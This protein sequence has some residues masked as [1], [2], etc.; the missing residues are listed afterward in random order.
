M[1]TTLSGRVRDDKGNPLELVVQFFLLDSHTGW[2]QV[3]GDR[4][5]DPGTGQYSILLNVDGYLPELG[6]APGK[7]VT[8]WVQIYETKIGRRIVQQFVK[9]DMSVVTTTIDFTFKDA[10]LNGYTVTAGSGFALNESTDNTF[11]PLIDNVN[12]WTALATAIQGAKKRILFTSLVIN[13]DTFISFA[14]G[15]PA[16]GT[17]IVDG[18]NGNT[19][20]KLI[21]DAYAR[22]CEV[23]LL[24]HQGGVGPFFDPSVPEKRFFQA[25]VNKNKTATPPFQMRFI[26]A[27]ITSPMHSKFVIIDDTTAFII[28]SPL[29]QCYFADTDHKIENLRH[30]QFNYLGAIKV[31]IHDVSVKFAGTAVYHLIQTFIQ[32]WNAAIPDGGTTMFPDPYPGS[33][34]ATDTYVQVLR[35]VPPKLFDGDD[36]GETNIEDAYLRAIALANDYIYIEDQYFTERHIVDAI[37]R[38]LLA[39]SKLQLIL[40]LNTE[41]DIDPYILYQKGGISRI[42]IEFETR[43][44]PDAFGKQ[45]GIY[46][47][48][49]NEMLKDAGG[50]L[51]STLVRNYI[52]SKTAVIDDKWFTIGSANLDGTA[53]N[54]AQGSDL[55]PA[56]PFPS[57]SRKLRSVE[58]NLVVNGGKGAGDL[59]VKLWSEHLGV[60]AADLDAAKRPNDGWITLWNQRAQHFIDDLNSR[61]P[62]ASDSHVLPLPWQLFG[63]SPL[64]YEISPTSK[65]KAGGYLAGVGINVFDPGINV[66]LELKPFDLKAGKSG[67]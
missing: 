17:P 54:R 9:V 67:Q 1:P 45:V 66:W 56:N 41:F 29:Y 50:A 25:T 58:T 37:T 28:G 62:K 48:W 32:L 19:I 23:R 38:R 39:N 43:L 15:L 31:P 49:S 42:W 22:G 63:R 55:F 20:G 33:G 61:P 18:T 7:T 3:G 10:D 59:R 36:I 51:R 12:A 60:P 5:S 44:G 6:V 46:S 27:P 35:T 8:F 16:E 34:P 26:D 52:H 14:T 11:E 40:L 30:G 57:N 64:G 4:K 65:K 47:R 21:N 24:F 53:I 13:P 2:T